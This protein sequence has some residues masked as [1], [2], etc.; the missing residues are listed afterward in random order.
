MA[1][2]NPTRTAPNL[3]PV[4]PDPDIASADV[5]TYA[6]TAAIILTTIAQTAGVFSSPR[7]VLMQLTMAEHEIE[8]AARRVR[9]TWGYLG[10]L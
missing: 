3:R 7:D 8:A 10:K 2:R 9:R 5:R 6:E 4:A 1:G